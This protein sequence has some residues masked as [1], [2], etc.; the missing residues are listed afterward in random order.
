MRV[1]IVTEDNIVMVDGKPRS[2]DCSP[3]IEE[4]IRAV[5]WRD[6]AG[7]VE[8]NSAFDEENKMLARKPNEAI[9]D[10]GPYQSYI[11]QWNIENDKQ[12][13]IEA[14]FQKEIE[15]SNAAMQKQIDDNKAM[16]AEHA[17]T[18]KQAMAFSKLPIAVQQQVMQAQLP[19]PKRAALV[20]QQRLAAWEK[21]SPDEQQRLIAEA[22][23]MKGNG[24]G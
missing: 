19:D 2:V 16:M 17:E 11:D 23:P 7:E 24:N 14:A 9:A 21:L 22:S 6:A 8:F 20:E 12:T 18:H 15:D 13:E 3:L 1:T 5:Q 10:I 4:G